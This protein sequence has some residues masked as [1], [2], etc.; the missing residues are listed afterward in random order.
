[1]KLSISTTTWPKDDPQTSAGNRMREVGTGVCT[2]T[3]IRARGVE[4]VSNCRKHIH[5]E[6]IGCYSQL[7]PIV[8]KQDYKHLLLDLLIFQ[9]KQ[10]SQIFI[11]N[12]PIFF[13]PKYY[14]CQTNLSQVYNLWFRGWLNSLHLI[15][16][17][18]TEET[19]TFI[20]ARMTEKFDQHAHWKQLNKILLNL[21]KLTT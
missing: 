7:Q 16:P 13:F 6:E 8:A 1:M 20:P 18:C 3:C 10:D 15:V 12:L 19:D 11:L 9:E 5:S 17:A 2:C 14:M 21:Y 4:T